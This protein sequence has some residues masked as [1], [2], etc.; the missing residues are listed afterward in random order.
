MDQIGKKFQEKLLKMK[1][2]LFIIF[3]PFALICQTSYGFVLDGSYNI[4]HN[5][6][7]TASDT[8]GQAPSAA[9]IPECFKF[10]LNDN[11]DQINQ[12]TDSSFTFNYPGVYFINMNMIV[13]K[14]SNDAVIDELFIYGTKNRQK[15]KQSSCR[16]EIFNDNLISS[17][18]YNKNYTLTARFAASD[19]LK[20]KYVSTNSNLEFDVFGADALKPG[21]PAVYLQ[22]FKISE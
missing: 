22:I 6:H 13:S 11:S 20:L 1:A 12:L 16:Y 17:F 10:N 7:I 8:V 2:I 15:I 4:G 9:N 3:F 5:C 18:H 19:T 21:V 14:S